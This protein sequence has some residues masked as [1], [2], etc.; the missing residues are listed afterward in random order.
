MT[1]GEIELKRLNQEQFLEEDEHGSTLRENKENI[2]LVWFDKNIES[3]LEDIQI[4][5]T[6]L[7]QVNDYVLFFVDPDFCIQYIK[8]IKSE[9]IFLI[10]SG[11]DAHILLS[12]VHDLRQVD[13]VY[14]FCVDKTKYERTLTEGVN[15]FKIVDIFTEQNSLIQ[16]IKYNVELVQKQGDLFNFYNQNQKST[17]NLTKESAAFLWH[18]LLREVFQ[19]TPS[20]DN[21]AKDEMLQKCR[22]YYR[23]N[24]KELH[25]IE[26]FNREYNVANAIEWYTRDSFVFK[27]INKAL[28]TEDVE[29]LY[30]YRFYLIDLCSQLAMNHEFVLE[31]YN[32]LTLYRGAKLTLDEIHR[33]KDS[34]GHLI[35][36]NGFL[37]TSQNRHVAEMYA[38][39]GVPNP[40][41]GQ[42]NL[43][44]V[45]FEINY[46]T[47][48]QSSTI[49]ANITYA[50]RFRDEEEFLFDLG[51]VFEIDGVIRDEKKQY[52]L[53]KMTPSNKGPEIVNEF[54]NY[55]RKQMNVS[56]VDISVLF[57]NLLYEM[58]E[59]LKCQ[60]YF[61]NL[62]SIQSS[63][64]SLNTIEIYRGLGRA[65]LGVGKLELS[66]KYLQNAYDSC[67]K[68]EPFSTNKLGPILSYMGYT[69]DFQGKYDTALNY[70]FKALQ[71]YKTD[72]N[73][74]NLIAYVLTRIGV[75]YYHKGQDDL[76][77]KY[78]KDSYK[79]IENVVP[80][81]HPEMSEYYNNMC[82][83]HYHKGY[84]DEALHYQ[85]KSY[86]IDQR[87]FPIDN[88]IDLSV[89]LNNIGKCYY[90][91]CQYTEALNYF[92]KSL[93]IARKVLKGDD[94]YLDMG[95][96]INNIGK[97][98]YRLKHYSDALEQYQIVLK[99]IEKDNV[100]DHVDE[101]YT[102][103]NIGEVYLDLSKYELS[104]NYFN[105]ALDIYKKTFNDLPNRDIAK[106]LHLLGQVYYSRNDGEDDS[107]LCE[108][109]YKFALETWDNVLPF[110][111]PDLALCYKTM[112]MFHLNRKSDHFHS[113]KYFSMSYNIYTK[114]LTDDHPY[115][116]DMHKLRET[117]S[118]FRRKNLFFM[119]VDSVELILFLFLFSIIFWFQF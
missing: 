110:N 78:F 54:V 89:D 118:K 76:A 69:Y 103:K 59:Y 75:T 1:S 36:T 71:I 37:S 65:C 97:C 7:R 15:Y 95:M 28:R 94:N 96:R 44:S 117:I 53:C 24:K 64:E 6:R 60:C 48:M 46:N 113:E 84:Y 68:L 42:N 57:G 2:T 50:S 27:L 92:N 114:T 74:K 4:T 105:R 108:S 9:I 115:L 88:H 19:K 116:M 23:G 41:I 49:V 93:D 14:I 119:T 90:K 63:K 72:L 112:S 58:G 111:H 8:S 34:I 5:K 101:A 85:E 43:E 25:N 104:I 99:L 87:I 10:S 100:N 77:L 32:S 83:V 70:Y 16:S 12:K 39:I 107:N 13:S 55:Q 91:K 35:S 11:N 3:N 20:G 22:L 33:L 109:Y 62:L 80:E 29:L 79:F 38:G 45:I 52:W 81:D 47:T 26:V 106:C 82:M 17:R 31:C 56:T 67:I 66:Q 86:E 40:N 18:Q 73:N 51:T 61:E 102:L 30:T 98:F 21:N